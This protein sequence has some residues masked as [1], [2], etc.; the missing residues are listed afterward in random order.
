[1]GDGRPGNCQTPKR[2]RRPSALAD[3]VWL[4]PDIS[5]CRQVRR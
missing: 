5:R 1:M 4:T 2:P 3:G